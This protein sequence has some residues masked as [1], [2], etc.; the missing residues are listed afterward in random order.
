MVKLFKNYS[1]SELIES[2]VTIG[3]N[4]CISNDVLFH[5]PQNIFIGDNS[6]ID[7]HCLMLA[8]K[9]N[10]IIIGKNVHVSA[11]CYYF[12]GGGDIILEDFSGTSSNVVIY[13]ASDDFSD[14]YMTNPTVDIIYRKVTNGNV[15]LKKHT[16]VGSGT[17]ILPNVILEHGTSVGANSVVKNSTEPFDLIAGNPAKFIKKRKNIF[18]N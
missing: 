3:K 14:G 2:G 1:A 18:L 7:S 5:N 8:G 13:S 15:I 12:G 4:V 10:K 11:G 17:I 16:I 6:R 9:N